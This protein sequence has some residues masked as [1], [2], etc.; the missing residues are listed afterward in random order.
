MV[1]L[2]SKCV[3]TLCRVWCSTESIYDEFPDGHATTDASD[4]ES[5]YSQSQAASRSVQQ[6]N[7]AVE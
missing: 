1:L 4:S 6:T 5:V 3:L 2:L 7:F